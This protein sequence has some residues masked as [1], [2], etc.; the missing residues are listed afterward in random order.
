MQLKLAVQIHSTIV[1]TQEVDSQF[2]QPLSFC[3]GLWHVFGC[4]LLAGGSK[5]N[6]A[7][8]YFFSRQC[9]EL[10]RDVM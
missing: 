8:T 7:H 1:A 4:L 5:F 10:C 9:T 2:L 3:S 6:E